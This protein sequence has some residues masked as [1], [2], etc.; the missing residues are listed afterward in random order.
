MWRYQRLCGTGTPKRLCN[1]SV[2]FYTYLP[3]VATSATRTGFGC[4]YWFRSCH[5]VPVWYWKLWSLLRE[6]QEGGL[7][8]AVDGR[9]R[10]VAGCRGWAALMPW[11]MLFL[12]S[13]APCQISAGKRGCAGDVG[14][15]FWAPFVGY[16][17][18]AQNSLRRIS[19]LAVIPSTAAALPAA[20]PGKGAWG[21][22]LPEWCTGSG[23]NLWTTRISRP[24]CD[25]GT[26]FLLQ[27]P[28]LGRAGAPARSESWLQSWWCSRD[29]RR[30]FW[31]GRVSS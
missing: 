10:R 14:R 5:T 8:T 21:G 17:S 22:S 31:W 15:R 13:K 7:A 18:Q 2:G 29:K 25:T 28:Q 4:L 19:G 3:G 9:G 16:T 26:I 20:V 27:P 6:P 30:H 23:H 1:R 24:S 11:K 12:S